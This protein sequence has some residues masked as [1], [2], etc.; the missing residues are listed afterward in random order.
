[1]SSSEWFCALLDT[2]PDVYFRYALEPERRVAYVSPAIAA[3]TGH[4]PEAFYA[5][6][7]LC[8]A[9]IAGADRRLLRRVLRARRDLVTTVHLV[10]DGVSLPVELRTV[11]LVRRRRLVAIEGVAR[12][13]VGPAREGVRRVAPAGDEPVQQR[14]AA[15]LIEVHDLLHRVVGSDRAIGEVSLPSDGARDVLP[16][17]GA[18]GLQ[19][20]GALGTRVLR[21]GALAL[22]SDRLVA[23]DDGRPVTL[24]PLEVQVLQ[25]LLERPGRVVTRPALLR[26]VWGYR[27]TGDDRTVDVHVSRLR[28]KLPVLRG[29]LTAL[30]GIGYRLDVDASDR[31]HAAGA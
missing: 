31:G 10:R 14:L 12:L 29:H 9:I 20:R 24:T 4:A 7:A 6:P 15:L 13:V 19:A 17:D 11:A 18:P 1:M 3:L 27:Y 28:R 2:A 30:R 21:L 25:Y 23:T 16:L 8:F 26:D 5:D 22:D